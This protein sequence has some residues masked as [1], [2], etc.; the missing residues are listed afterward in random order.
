MFDKLKNKF[1]IVFVLVYFDLDRLFILICD[2]LDI[3][4]GYVLG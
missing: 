1:L 2:V 4:I 3:V